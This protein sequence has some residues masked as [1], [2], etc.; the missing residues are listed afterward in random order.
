MID[1]SKKRIT[2]T[3]GAGFLGRHIV[4]ELKKK[5]CTDIFVPRS[6]DYD[7]RNVPSARLALLKGKPHIV[8]H[9]AAHAGGIGLNQERPAELFF[10]NIMM[11]VNMVDQAQRLGFVEKFVTLGTVCEYPK[12]T[13]TPFLEKDLW[14]GYPEETNA[15]YA[16]A[17]KALLVMGQAYRKQYGF[18][19]IHLLPANLYGPHDN[20]GNGSHVIPALIKKI[21]EAKEKSIPQV[22][23]WGTGTAS[24]EFLH[25]ED[26]ARAIVLATELYNKPE[27]INIGTGMGVHIADLAYVLCNMI[28]YSGDVLFDY[29]KPD[30]QP[31]R[32]LDVS[33]ACAEFG[34]ESKIKLWEGLQ[35]TI[36]WYMEN[37][38]EKNDLEL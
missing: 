3:G 15:P 24:R 8:I 29:T 26:A 20:F 10:D 6:E 28:N 37:K 4:E 16:I 11:G 13:T 18:N 33:K 2:V 25:V 27:P 36:D 30:G 19:V 31:S 35:Q 23:V 5:G 38:G 7:L 21:V 22:K 34:F 17:K 1:L 14:A 9:A 32:R 12:F